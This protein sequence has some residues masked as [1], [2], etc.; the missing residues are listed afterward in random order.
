MKGERTLSDGEHLLDGDRAQR[1]VKARSTQSSG[2][3]RDDHEA[4]P[5]V[6]LGSGVTTLA[7]GDR[8]GP[9]LLSLW[10]RERLWP[11][12]GGAA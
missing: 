12:R 11:L 2:S 10:P 8:P 7:P 4:T 6:Q 3:T 5:V 9:L 1:P